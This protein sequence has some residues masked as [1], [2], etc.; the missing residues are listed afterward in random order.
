MA[1]STGSDAKKTTLIATTMSREPNE[2]DQLLPQE[3]ENEKQSV[4]NKILSLAI[5][6][7]GALLLD[8]LMSL[9][10]VAFVGRFSRGPDALAGMG[11]AASLLT[12]SFY[13]CNFLC[14][15]TTPLVASKRA[16]N[17]EEQARAVGGQ[18]L[19]LAAT[20]GGLLIAIL[21]IFGQP[22]LRVMGTENTGVIASNY[23]LTFLSIRALAAPAVLV[24]EA[25]TG[26]LRGY[27]DTKTPIMVLIGANMLNL[28]L[29]VILIVYAGL[30]PMGA[31]I[32][33][34]SAEWI[35][36]S[37][38][39][40]VLSGKLPS[41][42]EEKKLQ[43]TPLLSVPSFEDVKPLLVASGSVLLRTLVLQL[44]LSTAAAMAA[45]GGS[46]AAASI[47][48]HQVGIQLWLL[49]SFFCDSLAAASQGLVADALGRDD[50]KDVL[51]VANTVF[52][53]SLILG[54]FLAAL[55]QVGLSSG[56]LFE[57][58]SKDTD[59]RACLSEILPFIIIAQPLNALVF[60]ADGVLQGASQ[61]PYQ[62]KA[63]LISGLTAVSTFAAM[64]YFQVGS[65]RLVHVWSALIAL[66][67][68]RGL[69][70][71]WKLIDE[72]GPINLLRK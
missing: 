27:L 34:T 59:V 38:F 46:V 15:A 43:I 5:P 33:T 18:A 35:S 44:S 17:Q 66:Q 51:E 56:L 52:L 60:S 58:F 13:L 10:D 32:A 41:A 65:E 31:A 57:L 25:S 55:L 36:A 68:M 12:F 48:A 16:A 30:G 6:A 9:A 14:T 45:R 3:N 4:G 42:G 61:F 72:E 53:Y 22:L 37:I 71:L 54:L 8:P 49:C 7:A 70:S 28:L 47:A 63:M 39:L 24:L 21:L 62:A 64:E 19:T 26:I 23:A 50:A 2:I 1:I 40:A 11:S 29:D 67:V 20:L 69:T